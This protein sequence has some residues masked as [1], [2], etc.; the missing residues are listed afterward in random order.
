MK[1]TAGK[2]RRA[3]EYEK[4][5]AE[6]WKKD[7]TFE[8]SV[9]NRDAKIAMFFMT[10]RHLLPAC[11]TTALSS[12]LSL[13]TPSRAT[14]PCAA[15]VSNENGVGTVMASPLKISSKNSSVLPTV[16]KSALRLVLKITF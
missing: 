8:K 11:R 12:A 5:I 16:A 15:N 7:N 9:A 1:Y 10:A 6:W 14:G 4:A 13:K 3:I 2:R